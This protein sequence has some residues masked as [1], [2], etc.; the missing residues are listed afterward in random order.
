[1]RLEWRAPTA[2][3]TASADSHQLAYLGVLPECHSVTLMCWHSAFDQVVNDYWLRAVASN[4][5]AA[6]RAALFAMLLSRATLLGPPRLLSAATRPSLC[7]MVGTSAAASAL[8]RWSAS[9]SAT[10]GFGGAGY[11]QPTNC[12]PSQ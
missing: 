6:I 8:R 12:H 9:F 1:M 11:G 10:P 2:L 4:S 3:V 7:V 5:D